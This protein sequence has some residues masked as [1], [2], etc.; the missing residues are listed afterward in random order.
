MA[1]IKDV[2]TII[3]DIVT[4][5]KANLNTQITA[6]NTEK[7]DSLLGPVSGDAYMIQSLNNAAVNFNPFI[8]IPIVG[9]D[10]EPIGPRSKETYFIQIILILSGVAVDSNAGKKI[11][12]YRRV[13][14]DLIKRNWDK[15]S[16]G[17]R[18]EI[19]S[20]T[21]VPVE[22]EN[23]NDMHLATGVELEFVLF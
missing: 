9:I 22:L 7:G 2:E 10:S 16:P 11:L 5:L 12:R 4:F 14:S 8:F 1:E 13:L 18:T 23:S 19:R 15:I 20:L 17:E 3:D 6:M 21:P